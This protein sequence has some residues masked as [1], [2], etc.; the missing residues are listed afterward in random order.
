[1]SHNKIATVRWAPG[2]VAGS[3]IEARGRKAATFPT[4]SPLSPRP[5]RG[6]GVAERA[7]EAIQHHAYDP[8]RNSA[9]SAPS[10]RAGQLLR[11]RIGRSPKPEL[12]RAPTGMI[13]PC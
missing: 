6:R 4:C 8:Y 5:G 7:Y 11:G 2:R 10:M 13:A 3:H 9:R 1:M 12:D